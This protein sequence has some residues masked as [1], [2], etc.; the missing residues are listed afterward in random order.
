MKLNILILMIIFF[1]CDFK[2]KITFLSRLNKEITPD[3][4]TEKVYVDSDDVAIWYNKLQPEK[5]LIFGTDKGNST[6]S[7]SLFVFDIHGKEISKKTVKNLS[8]P[9]NVDVAYGFK[10]LNQHIDIVVFTERDANRIRVFKIPEMEQI[11]NGGIQVFEGETLKSPMGIGLF[12]SKDGKI[13]AIVSRSYGPSGEYLWQYELKTNSK[14]I[15]EGKLARKFGYFSQIKTI[16]AIAVDNELGYVY[17]SDERKAIRKYYAHPDSSNAELAAFGLNDFEEDIEGI[18]IYKSSDSTG[19]II[20]SD[21]EADL[22]QIYKRE[23]EQNNPHFHPLE[24]S[25]H[26]STHDSDGNEVTH[27]PLPGFPEG[28]FIA[29]SSNKTFHYYDWLDIKPLLTK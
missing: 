17:Y 9:N 12:K 20:V 14:G 26:L 23:G 6:I 4:V 27:M 13:F 5:S 28:L 7:G 3:I 2:N 15:T 21:Q 18:S 25:I 24:A 10:Y 29:M 16:E 11:D 19:F 22:F 1:G 8:R